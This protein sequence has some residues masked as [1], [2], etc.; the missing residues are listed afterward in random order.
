MNF[1]SFAVVIA[2]SRTIVEE[3]TL[4]PRLKLA[5]RVWVSCLKMIRLAQGKRSRELEERNQ[6]SV[7]LSS[8]ENLT[9]K[10][11]QIA[12]GLCRQSL[13]KHLRELE[14]SGLVFRDTVKPW[15]RMND[16]N[17]LGD[18]LCRFG[19]CHLANR[20]YAWEHKSVIAHW[21]KRDRICNFRR[22]GDVFYH[23][24]FPA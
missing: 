4:T 21:S 1:V 19:V 10:Q 8:G 17:V 6:V 9:F 7:W 24:N 15:E 23:M 3:M 14:K 5:F 16:A 11:L 18:F 22:V 13:M 12:T 2:F 20:L